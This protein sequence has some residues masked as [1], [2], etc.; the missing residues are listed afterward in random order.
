MTA[1]SADAVLAGCSYF[2]VRIPRH[3]A[4]D[5]D[6]MAARGFGGVLHTFSENDLA[7]YADT[8][9]RIVDLSHER[10]LEVQIG[11]WG[12]G[13]TFGGEAES[14]FLTLRPDTWQTLDDGRRVGAACLNHPDYRAFLKEW[15]DAALATGADLVFWDEPHWVVPGHVG[16][17]DRERWGCC[18]DLCRERFGR[19]FP[20]ELDDEVLAFR[21]ASL[22]D[23][24][25][26][27][28]AHVRERGGRNTVCLLPADEGAHGIR[29]W[30]AIAALPGLDVLATDPYWH[31]YGV[32]VEP[33][34]PKFS[35]LVAETAARHGVE[36]EVWLP[37]YRLERKDIPDFE[38][39]VRA[40][41]AAGV[42]RLWVWGYEA[43]GHMSHLASPDADEVWEAVVRAVCVSEPQAPTELVRSEHSDL[44]A[45]S[46]RELVR[47]MNVEDASVPGA[48]AAAADEIADAIDAVAA[49]LAGGGRLIYV[50]AGTSGRIA[51]IDAAECTSTF[52][53][54]PERV[55]AVVARDDAAEDDA[56]AGA[57]E[58]RALEPTEAD[59]VVGV[60]AS[61]RTPYA[62][63][64]LQAA[65]ETGAETIA[66]TC[67]PDGELGGAAAREVCV[68]VGP[69]LIAGST[70]LKAGT[71][72]KLVLNMLS[73]IAMVRLG[74]TY[75][76]LMVD[77]APTNAKL[78]ERIR[79]IV[80]TATGATP[81]RADK[82]LEAAG[83]SAKVAIVSLLA[84]VD[85]DVARDRL[86]NAD[87]N[88]RVALESR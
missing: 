40:V 69:E 8:M 62:V 31:G 9:R 13:R 84:D 44:D 4:R 15:A 85:P 63:A 24:L 57:S 59:V 43:C 50:G 16:V 77:V 72:Q 2:G 81:E 54:P 14:R 11:P 64:A 74:K 73:T 34:V 33:F 28:V 49:R 86:A 52:S 66:L 37:A 20:A 7:Y 25:G 83:G 87:D 42:E 23:F 30:D 1:A 70:R 38:T 39:A 21:D 41:R 47:L 51:A 6:D 26:E 5:L 46:T 76:N 65:R 75:G 56:D 88:V 45:R 79:S 60:S 19:D 27:L 58:L 32:P 12:L 36:P 61:G 71:A 67:A 3:V 80:R 82:A 68:V 48:V 78:R 35:A 55:V 22:A 18:C 10:G 17:E 53:I 29:D